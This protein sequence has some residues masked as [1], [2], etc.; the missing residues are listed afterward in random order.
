M[1]WK[2]KHAQNDFFLAYRLLF[3][4]KVFTIALAQ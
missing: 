4:H 3:I 1:T 2:P